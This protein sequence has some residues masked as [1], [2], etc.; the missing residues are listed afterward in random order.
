MS[1]TIMPGGEPY[2]YE[3]GEV[4]CVLVHGFTGTPSCFRP[5]AEY[6]ADKGISAMAVR[7]KGHGTTVEEM[8][9]C[10]YQDW[11]DSAEDGL[12]ALQ[13]YCK[14]VFM[15]GLSMG[16]TISLH[17]ACNRS[18]EVQ[19][20]VTICSPVIFKDPRMHVAPF[21]KH[22]VK[23][24]P[25]IAGN[26]KDPNAVEIAYEQTPVPAIEQLLKLAAI[27]KDEL[28]SIRQPS[29]IFASGEDAVVNPDNGRVIFENIGSTDKKLIWLSNSYHVATLDYDKEMISAK[30]VDFVNRLS[31]NG[32]S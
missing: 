14:K 27:V 20:V 7:L 17:V 15:V 29:M 31:G 10:N 30:I 18:E 24:V 22:I 2:F 11:V 19:G 25:S 4:G 5:V 12:Q 8:A 3:A 21:M 26:M 13:K 28:P 1:E 32:Q 23:K 6:L 9:K 16:G